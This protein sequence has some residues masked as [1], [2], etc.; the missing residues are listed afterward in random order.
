[1]GAVINTEAEMKLRCKS[2]VS[3]SQWM[4]ECLQNES[5]AHEHY[6]IHFSWCKHPELLG[7]LAW[8]MVSSQSGQ[9][10]LKWTGDSATSIQAC[11]MCMTFPDR[12]INL[13]TGSCTLWCVLISS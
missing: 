1:V 6:T 5:R 11:P 7:V 3:W 4:L 12:G 10:L 13:H 9:S 8:C 2:R